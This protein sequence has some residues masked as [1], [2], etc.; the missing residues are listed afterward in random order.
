MCAGLYTGELFKRFL[1]APGDA[2]NDPLMEV[3]FQSARENSS[4][5]RY[6]Y[7]FL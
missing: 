4:I 7:S 5:F 1:E 3:E 6:I 2:C